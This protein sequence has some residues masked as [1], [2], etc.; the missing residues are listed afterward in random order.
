LTAGQTATIAAWKSRADS[1]T[2][3]PA[4]ALALYDSIVAVDDRNAGLPVRG[5]QGGLC[6]REFPPRQNPFRESHG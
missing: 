5:G 2:A 6:R 3:K 1:L 4:E